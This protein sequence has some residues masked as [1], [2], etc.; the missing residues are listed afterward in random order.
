MATVRS[1]PYNGVGAE[2]SYNGRSFEQDPG[3]KPL[4][5]AENFPN[6]LVPPLQFYRVLNDVMKT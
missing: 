6:N 1:A 3:T 4:V 5:G 2:R